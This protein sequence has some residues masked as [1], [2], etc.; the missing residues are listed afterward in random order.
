LNE[1][2]LLVAQY[3]HL[4]WVRRVSLALENAPLGLFA[5]ELTSHHHCRFGHWYYG[6]GQ[7]TYGHLPQFTAIEPVH[8][9]V[10]ETGAEIIRLCD[11]GEIDRARELLKTLLG[12]KD[13][14]LVLTHALQVAVLE[15]NLHEAGQR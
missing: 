14:I 10:H 6:H 2:P 5:A 9:R 7:A 1:V 3:D 15:T 4:Q 11:G 13:Q 8:V 12:L